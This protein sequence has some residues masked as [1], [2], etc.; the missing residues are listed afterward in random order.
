M[1]N[2][3]EVSVIRSELGLVND[4]KQVFQNYNFT[5]TT[6]QVGNGY[7]FKAENLG[8]IG[9]SLFIIT[10]NVPQPFVWDTFSGADASL[11]DHIGEIG[12]TW[13][14]D[15]GSTV[16]TGH[17]KPHDG[18]HIASGVP[19]TA[20]YTVTIKPIL[21]SP[22]NY[23]LYAL[24]RV[25]DTTNFYAASLGYSSG[26]PTFTLIKVINAVQ[27]DFGS[28]TP[29][30]PI[31]SF[32]LKLDGSTLKLLVNDVAVLQAT[33]PDLTAPGSVGFF[34]GEG[35]NNDN[36]FLDEFIASPLN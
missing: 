23:L 9:A 7:L 16:S 24:G 1:I 14:N 20:D 29:V 17:C 5:V 19:P 10:P 25:V 36:V 32:G 34:G 8:D 31:E 33:D 22:F 6:E 21:N 12:A 11:V 3:N 27:T 26:I 18:F 28:F 2:W 15:D 35:D 13:T 4:L 30:D